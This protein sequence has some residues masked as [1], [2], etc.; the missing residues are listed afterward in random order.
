MSPGPVVVVG[1]GPAGMAAA[2]AAAGAGAGVVL[3]D[4]GPLLGGQYHRQNTLH[5]GARLAL[6]EGVEHVPEAE[7]WALEHLP[8]DDGGGHRVH[9]RCGPADG[10]G[11]HGRTVDTPALVLATGAYD[12]VLP[13]P[14]WDL[15]GVCTA[16]AGQ[17]LAKG[18]GVPVGRRVVVA[19]TGPFLLPVAASLA[20][21]GARVA[22][23]WEANAVPGGWLADLAGCGRAAGRRVNWPGMPPC[24]LAGASPAGSAAR[25][26]QR[27]AG[28]GWRR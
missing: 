22:G 1:G 12:R 28:T 27:T 6:P 10:P 26:S 23:V 17:A 4:S 3:A 7:V 14:G 16:G 15:P 19:G 11:R 13:F 18:Q 8:D 9:L 24:W 2:R 25:S 21:V 20:Q 5:P